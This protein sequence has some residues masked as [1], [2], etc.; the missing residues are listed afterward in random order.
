MFTFSFVIHKTS[1]AQVTCSIIDTAEL[2]KTLTP[3]DFT[4]GPQG[5]VVYDPNFDLYY[6]YQIGSPSERLVTY[7]T[8]GNSIFST[9]IGSFDYRGSWFNPVTDSIEVNGFALSGLY[10]PDRNIN[11]FLQNTGNIFLSAAQPGAQS[12]GD[13]NPNANQIVYYFNGS[14]YIYNRVNNTFVSFFDVT[15]LPV[16]TSSLNPHTV[17]YTNCNG[18]EYGLLDRVN[19]RIHFVNSTGAYTGSS[20]IPEN[21]PF[22][23][24]FSYAND[25]AWVFNSDSAKWLG[26]NVVTSCTNPIA[27]F[28]ATDACFGDTI[29]FQ[30]NSSFVEDSIVLYNWNFGDGVGSSTEQNPF[31]IYSDPGTYPVSLEV[32]NVCGNT[33]FFQSF[34][35][36]NV[37][38]EVDFSSVSECAEIEVDFTDNTTLGTDPSGSTIANWFWDFGD[39]TGSSTD[40]NPSYPFTAGGNYQVTLTV[41]TNFGC[42]DS[43]TETVSVNSLPEASFTSGITCIDNPVQFTNTSTI[44]SGNIQEYFWDFGDGNTDTIENPLNIFTASGNFDVSL[45]AISDEGCAD[46]VTQTIEVFDLPVVSISNLPDFCLNDTLYEL[47]EG[48]NHPQGI[49]TGPGVDSNGF[50][51][52]SDAGV[53]THTITY[54]FIDANGCEN[55][56]STTVSVSD[57]PIVTLGSFSELCE[58][59]DI[60]ILSG[61]LPTGGDYFVDGN[62]SVDFDP[63]LNGPGSYL[64]EYVY[65]DPISLCPNT[66]SQTLVVNP[67]PTVTLSPFADICEDADPITLSGGN[68]SGGIYI[69]NGNVE[70]EFD[71]SAFGVGISTIFYAFTDANGC[72]DT[73]ST[74]IEV[75]SSPIVTLDP[76]AP[77]CESD[78]DFALSGGSP[79]GGIYFI[80]GTPGV[81][82]SPSSLGAGF[83]TITYEYT[84]SEGCTSSDSVQIEVLPLPAVTLDAFADVCE[85]EP[86]FT[87]SGGAP[88]GG[89]Y[90]I[91]GIVVT[92]FDPSFYGVGITNVFYAYEDVN[93]CIDTASNTIEV[94]P[95][96]IV[97][98]PVFSDV[99]IDDEPFTLTGGTPVGG[100]YTGT[101]VSSNIFNPADAGVGAHI[102][103][104]SFT[105]TNGC[106]AT[107]T[108]SINVNPL[109]LVTID[110]I[111]PLCEND[112]AIV[113]EIGFPAGGVYTVDGVQ[114]NI[115]DPVALGFGQFTIVYEFT[116]ANGCSA[117]DSTIVNI[118]PLPEPDFSYIPAC[119]NQVNF[120]TNLTTI[121]EGTIVSYS[122]DLGDGSVSNIANPVHVYTQAGVYDVTLTAV[123]DIGC[124]ESITKQVEVFELPAVSIN[125][126]PEFCVSESQY[127]LTEGSQHPQGVYS[128]TGVDN[129]GVFSAANAGIGTHLI[130]YTY[131]DSNGCENSASTTVTVNPLPQVSLDPIGPFCADAPSVPLTNGIPAGGT[132][133]VNGVISTDFDPA[134]TGS[135]THTIVYEYTDTNGCSNSA[136]ISVVVNPLPTVSLI[137]FNGVCIDEPVFQLSGGIPTGGDYIINGNI[138]SEFDASLYGTGTIDIFYAYTD[139]NGCSDTAVSGIEVYDLPVVSLDSINDVC[140]D[141]GSFTLT[142]GI[143]T[144]GVYSGSGV[145]GNVFSPVAAGIGTHLI[146]YTYVDSNGCE[147][148]ASTTVTV[149]PLP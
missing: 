101:G 72:S 11:G 143:P 14:I 136:S 17:I 135:G 87:L 108:A 23:Y 123:S 90:L 4:S 62:L 147:N 122:W 96:P 50:F 93:G 67:T 148:S 95:I 52:P 92:E 55:S 127:V 131:V 8:M 57:L 81:D 111:G 21:V 39:G 43:I 9:V 79:V 129:N 13:L 121:S 145:T 12:M 106:E 47:T 31:Y 86:T 103:T 119:E 37:L 1:T 41:E 102:I 142:G 120:F 34:V 61:G 88:S 94:L 69:V 139:I 51:D 140:I 78:D 118:G 109:P 40:Q 59:D 83:F 65:T 85:N 99:C 28:N 49:Y 60:L 36:V 76:F 42:V 89:T 25:L 20:Q 53:G 16:P 100:T 75:I 35:N 19:R 27:S 18:L 115:L 77:V 5:A 105:D 29:F 74:S 104:Y 45:V 82:F 117:S 48:S 113:L 15:G 10:H 63:T 110:S 44:S 64:I 126:L 130:T 58:E 134:L 97:D 138:V 149:N 116:D 71:P 24:G 3:P 70:T 124:T 137:S 73:A 144:G 125:T 68:P 46:T 141:E 91:N 26:Y 114:T 54:T 2:V 66:A 133:F 32:T 80:D 33:D 107:D 128:G 132:Y 7:D 38:P 22:Q 112:T 6:S 146:T 30:D 98:L 84:D 56:A